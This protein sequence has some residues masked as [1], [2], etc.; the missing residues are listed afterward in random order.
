MKY[1]I[2]ILMNYELK[3]NNK[4]NPCICQSRKMDN[5]LGVHNSFSFLNKYASQNR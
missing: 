4:I 1:H 5:L 2:I 3:Y